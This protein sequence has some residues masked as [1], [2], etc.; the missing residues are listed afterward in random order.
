MYLVLMPSRQ[1]SSSPALDDTL[2]PVSA[3][4]HISPQRAGST[5]RISSTIRLHVK[6]LDIGRL[7]S[8]SQAN[9]DIL[10]RRSELRCRLHTVRL[11]G[12]N[13]VVLL[14]E[15][16]VSFNKCV[17]FYAA[18]SNKVLEGWRSRLPKNPPVAS[19]HKPKDASKRVLS[20]RRYRNEGVVSKI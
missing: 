4:R 15:L 1:L 14:C 11:S 18:L 9:E 19:N 12:L 20:M 3:L 6:P 10:D 5:R 16:M 7:L 8:S 17:T 13:I 2:G